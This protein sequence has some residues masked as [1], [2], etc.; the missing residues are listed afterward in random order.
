MFDFPFFFIYLLVFFL[1]L[2][3]LNEFGR[4]LAIHIKTFN[5]FLKNR[6]S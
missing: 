2:Y 6:N 3:L 4:H 1:L 5:Y